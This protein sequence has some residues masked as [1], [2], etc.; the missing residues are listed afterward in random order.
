ME[1]EII[2]RQINRECDYQCSRTAAQSG[3]T[4]SIADFVIM[5]EL[6]L[7]KARIAL[8]DMFI[9]TEYRNVAK[10]KRIAMEN[11]LSLSTHAIIGMQSHGCPTVNGHPVLRVT[12][13]A[14]KKDILLPEG[15]ELLTCEY[16]GT[17]QERV[18]HAHM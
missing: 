18:S 7:K 5:M 12:C 14:C 11:I 9:A 1:R 15:L 13:N 8:Q 6:H 3:D 17:P 4:K 10:Q 2:F 16:C